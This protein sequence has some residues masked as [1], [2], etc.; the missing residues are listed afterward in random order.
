MNR[1]EANR[2]RFDRLIAR[3]KTIEEIIG[4]DELYHTPT[5]F[6]KK[7]VEKWLRRDAFPRRNSLRQF[8][9]CAGLTITAFEG[10]MDDFC[11]AL[12]QASH[13]FNRQGKTPHAYSENQILEAMRREPKTPSQGGLMTI[14]NHT[15]NAIGQKTMAKYFQQFQGYYFGYLNW[16]RWIGQNND[17]TALKGSIFRCLIKVDAL[18]DDL[19]VIRSKLTTSNH[20]EQCGDDRDNPW[21]YEGVMVPIPGQL[22]FIFEAP[23]PSFEEMDFVFI[24]TQSQPRD[25]L[26]GVVSSV[27]S[28]SDAAAVMKVQPTPAAARI[29][30]QK[31][32]PDMNEANLM[33]QLAHQQTP[34]RE[35]ARAIANEIHPDTGVL[36]SHSLPTGG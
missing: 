3:V 8:C 32:P 15:I 34:D 1:K 14:L 29:L 6:N 33:Q 24:M 21:A 18:D 26:V 9:Q 35:I 22:V 16:T 4:Y 19:H 2:D 13:T 27:S 10:S 23:E 31:A 36:M 28:V 30:L 7:T 5:G 11:R 20:L 12:A 25:H 17:Q